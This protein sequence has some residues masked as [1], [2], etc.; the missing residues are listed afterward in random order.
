MVIGKT[1]LKTAGSAAAF[2]DDARY[3]VKARLGMVSPPILLP[4]RG[5]VANGRLRFK[6]RVIEDEGIVDAP[7]SHSRW[8]NLKRSFRRYETDEIR[9]ALVEWRALGH[10]GTATSDRQGFFEV[11][12]PVSDVPEGTAWVPVD[13][14]LTAA[15]RYEF[16]PLR[17]QTEVRI[18]SADAEF[19]VISDMDDT[20]VET[21]ARNLLRHWRT[22]ALNSAEGRVAFPGVAC[23]FQALASGRSG[24]ETNPFFYVSSSPWNLYDLFEDFLGLRGIPHGPMFLKDFG[25][26]KTQWLS[27]SHRRHKLRAIQTILDA[28]PHLGFVLVGDTGQSDAKIYSEAVAAHPGRIRAVFLR[29]VTPKGF[30]RGVEKAIDEIAFTGVPVV[31]GPTLN[32]AAHKAEELGLVEPGTVERMGKQIAEDRDRLEGSKWPRPF[33]LRRGRGDG[34]SPTADG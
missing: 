32:A 28:Y 23:L 24:G 26:S 7:V 16:A 13:L 21:G 3:R 27:G 14:V 1:A 11:D 8:T 4:Y 25:L 30:R 19:G 10:S 34:E 17:A 33:G 22:V 15:P 9:D 18:V 20:V 6:G 31:S 12:T 29:D 2:W 5:F